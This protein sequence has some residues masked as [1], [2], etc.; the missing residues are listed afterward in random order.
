MVAKPDLIS[1]YR[2]DDVVLVPQSDGLPRQQITL[3][4]TPTWPFLN[5]LY[6]SCASYFAGLKFL[7]N[8]E[9]SF[10]FLASWE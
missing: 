2:R 1:G 5:L 6:S 9:K 3:V 10:I 8:T 4:R 7:S